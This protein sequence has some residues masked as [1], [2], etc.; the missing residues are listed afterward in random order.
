MYNIILPTF[1]IF[2]FDREVS[3]SKVLFQCPLEK[4]PPFFGIMQNKHY[5]CSV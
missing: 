4:V 3:Q 5:V 1:F 2:S